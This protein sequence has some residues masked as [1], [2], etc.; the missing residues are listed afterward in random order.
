NE[1]RQLDL[2]TTEDAQFLRIGAEQYRAVVESD[3]TVVLS[4]LRKVAGYLTGAADVMIAA[5][6]E[7]PREMGPPRPAKETEE[8]EE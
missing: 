4:L 1:P 3:K 2:L 6:L 5:G 7:V 8:A